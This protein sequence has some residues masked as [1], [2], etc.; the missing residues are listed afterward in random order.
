MFV[1]VYVF[2]LKVLSH[3]ENVDVCLHLV[4]LM[5]MHGRGDVRLFNLWLPPPSIWQAEMSLLLIGIPFIVRNLTTLS[6]SVYTSC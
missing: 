4:N 2:S 1:Y 3:F 5:I 6:S